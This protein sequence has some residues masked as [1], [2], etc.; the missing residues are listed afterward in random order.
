MTAPGFDAAG[1]AIRQCRFARQV[2]NLAGANRFGHYS[3]SRRLARDHF[4]VGIDGFQVY[5]NPG[6]QTA[7]AD[8]DDDS[9]DRRQLARDFD[10]AGTLPGNDGGIVVRRQVGHVIVGSILPRM[11]LG[12]E[13]VGAEEL[14]FSAGAANC[15]HLD[16]RCLLRHEND[17]ADA[18]LLHR[19]C[20]G[21]AMVAARCRDA[22]CL[23][24]CLIQR[25][26]L[27]ES[28]TRLERAGLLQI[29]EF[30]VDVGA[31]SFAENRRM[32]ERCL[33]N[34]ATDPVGSQHDFGRQSLAIH[35]RSV[36]LRK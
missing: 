25:H 17:A 30:Q 32:L 34:V 22:T 4:D 6:N 12:I 14:H 29:L 24:R 3:R 18:E 11:I 28:T 23:P 35:R 20:D 16:R 21:R 36:P 15:I 2:E 19:K 31:G 9:V 27:V 7:A 5:A 33:T 10:A 26:Q 13:P 1:G 8:G